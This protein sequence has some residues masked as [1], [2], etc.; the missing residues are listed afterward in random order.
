[1][2]VVDAPRDFAR[3]SSNASAELPKANRTEISK[4]TVRDTP[5]FTG[6]LKKVPELLE[7][8]G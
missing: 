8:L 4:Y 7:N 1:M 3:S 2:V 6:I 5:I